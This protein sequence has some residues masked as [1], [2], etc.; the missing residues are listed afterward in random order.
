G[1]SGEAEDVASEIF[2]KV[3]KGMAA[4]EGKSRF[5]TWLY[6]IA[7]NHCLNERRKRRTDGRTIPL[8]EAAEKNM[9]PVAEAAKDG[10]ETHERRVAGELMFKAMESL[11]ESQRMA[12]ILVKIQGNSYAETAE[13]MR[14]SVSAVESLIFRGMKSLRERVFAAE[15]K[16]GL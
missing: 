15:A 14:L 10:G 9:P 2:F 8:D 1:D 3:W 13:I 12:L 6:R 11:P 16:E 4:F 7:V 5:S